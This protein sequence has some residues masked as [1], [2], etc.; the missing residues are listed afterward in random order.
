M[1]KDLKGYVT[2]HPWLGE[3]GKTTEQ[4]CWEILSNAISIVLSQAEAGKKPSGLYK[5]YNCNKE[6]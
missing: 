4:L 3:K 1:I 2:L 5:K 6:I